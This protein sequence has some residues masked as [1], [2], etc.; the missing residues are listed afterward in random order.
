MDLF[1]GDQN[2]KIALASG[3]LRKTDIGQISYKA[4]PLQDRFF[5]PGE[6]TRDSGNLGAH[7]L[8]IEI[9]IENIHAAF[10]TVASESLPPEFEAR[11]EVIPSNLK[12][13]VVIKKQVVLKAVSEETFTFKCFFW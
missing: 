9:P 5:N 12:H 7:S 6:R 3:H 13:S 2:G 11:L 1:D 10:T 4:L 8:T